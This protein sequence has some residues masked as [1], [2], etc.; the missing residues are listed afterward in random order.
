MKTSRQKQSE[1]SD[2]SWMRP[3]LAKLVG[4]AEPN[5]YDEDVAQ[6]IRC[7]EALQAQSWRWAIEC[8]N[9]SSDVQLRN[10]ETLMRTRSL[11]SESLPRA[12]CLAIA[13]ALQWEEPK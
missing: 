7:L 1:M 5:A 13:A 10:P 9:G 12:I 4:D 8:E 2:L 11:G 6:A 3:L